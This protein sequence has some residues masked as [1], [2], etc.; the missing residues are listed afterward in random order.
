MVRCGH[1][2]FLYLRA[3]E[4]PKLAVAAFVDP[5]GN[6]RFFAINTNRTKFREKNPEISRHVFLLSE[7]DN[8]G[9]LTHDSWL[10]CEDVHGG[11]TVD[12]IEKENNCYRG[13]IDVATITAVKSIIKDSRLYSEAEKALILSQ[14]P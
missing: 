8:G 3:A 12:Q 14:W 1:V 13:P 4:K 5:K 9:F 7:K 2:Y 10:C 6:V 11:W